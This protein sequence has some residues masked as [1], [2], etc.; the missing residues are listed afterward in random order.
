MWQPFSPFILYEKLFL[1]L[2]GFGQEDMPG[3]KLCKL[4]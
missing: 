1:N 4:V 2:L 3:N